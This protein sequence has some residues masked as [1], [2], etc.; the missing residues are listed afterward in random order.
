[1]C[2]RD[3]S[4]LEGCGRGSQTTPSQGWSPISPGARR[5]HLVPPVPCA[6]WR[7][8]RHLRALGA[9]CSAQR[10]RRARRSPRRCALR[11]RHARRRR[12]RR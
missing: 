8:G 3:S 4:S 1:M 9:R 11:R 6:R 5:C 2:I 12:A 10:S 7:A